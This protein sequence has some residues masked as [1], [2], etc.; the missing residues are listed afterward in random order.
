MPPAPVATRPR[1]RACLRRRTTGFRAPYRR[2][3]SPSPGPRFGGRFVPQPLGC[4]RCGPASGSVPLNSYRYSP[5][6]STLQARVLTR[7]LRVIFASQFGN[8]SRNRPRSGH[9]GGVFMRPSPFFKLAFS[10]SPYYKTRSFSLPYGIASFPSAIPQARLSHPRLLSPRNF[11][12]AAQM[13]GC[14]GFPPR[15]RGAADSPIRCPASLTGPRLPIRGPVAAQGFPPAPQR[16]F[17]GR[18]SH[19]RPP[20]AFLA[21]APMRTH[22]YPRD[23]ASKMSPANK[24]VDTRVPAI[25]QARGRSL[26]R[27]TSNNRTQRTPKRHARRARRASCALR[28]RCGACLR[29]HGCD[30]RERTNHAARNAPT[31][32]HRAGFRRMGQ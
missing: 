28:A 16:L 2:P 23:R 13:K 6:V 15:V 21:R 9:E 14:A 20:F 32:E 26:P 11:P 5:F 22:K 27:P 8:F 29:Y 19:S 4:F 7:Y 12:S 25:Q 30:Q 24:R 3:A 10:R 1:R 31:E 18:A 17:G